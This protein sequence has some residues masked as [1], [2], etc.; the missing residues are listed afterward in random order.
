MFERTKKGFVKL[1]RFFALTFLLYWNQSKLRFSKA[2]F[3]VLRIAKVFSKHRD[4]PAI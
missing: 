2:V 3:D 1:Y 4:M